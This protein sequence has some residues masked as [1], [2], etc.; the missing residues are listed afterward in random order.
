MC[1]FIRRVAQQ[2]SVSNFTTLKVYVTY[3]GVKSDEKFD[4]GH[5]VSIT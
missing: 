5:G 3:R 4:I 1:T 2:F